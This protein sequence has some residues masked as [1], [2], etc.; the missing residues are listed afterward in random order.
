MGYPKVTGTPILWEGSKRVCVC[1]C[2]CVWVCV[3]VRLFV[4]VCVYV[5]GCGC[6]CVGVGV[7]VGVMG[8]ELIFGFFSEFKGVSE[9]STLMNRLNKQDSQ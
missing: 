7:G 9:L 5:C 8:R 4:C 6:M 3:C 2:V 1:V